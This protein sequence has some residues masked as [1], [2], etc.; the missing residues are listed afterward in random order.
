[1]TVSKTL[2]S[3]IAVRKAPGLDSQKTMPGTML[4]RALKKDEGK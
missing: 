3:L 1:M 4:L 2:F